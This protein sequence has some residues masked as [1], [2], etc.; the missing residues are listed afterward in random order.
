[1]TQTPKSQAPTTSELNHARARLDQLACMEFVESLEAF[2]AEYSFIQTACFGLGDAHFSLDCL[3]MPAADNLSL[4]EASK[5]Y[6]L[7]KSQRREA[8]GCPDE[9]SGLCHAKG[10]IAQNSFEAMVNRLRLLA[11]K[12]FQTLMDKHGHYSRCVV[13]SGNFISICKSLDLA[14]TGAFVER[15]R[16]DA[17]C[18]RPLETETARPRI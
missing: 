16:L 11:P 7:P 4:G 15:R 18:G 10:S 3:L 2:F 14:A 8:S 12:T 6:L 9:I 13:E 5:I 1:M 17:D